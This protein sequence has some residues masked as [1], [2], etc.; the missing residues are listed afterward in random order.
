MKKKMIK[1]LAL[2]LIV[3]LFAVGCQ[4][5]GD[6][7]KESAK[8]TVVIATSSEIISLNKYMTSAAA[9]IMVIANI[10]DS[11]VELDDDGNVIPSLAK[12]WE[13]SDDGISYTFNLEK[14]VKFQNGEELKASDVVFTFNTAKESP[15]SASLGEI[16]DNVKEIDEYTVEVNIIRPYA[17]FVLSLVEVPIFNEKAFDEAGSGEEYGKHPIGTGAYKFV[18]YELGQ[19]IILERFDDY[20]K[21][22]A[23]IKNLVFK[24]ISDMNTQLVALESGDIDFM[25]DVPGIAFDSVSKNEDLKI[26]QQE[27]AHLTF[28]A[29]NVLDET[30]NN[31]LLRQAIN[32]AIDKE[33]LV[34]MSLEGLGEIAKYPLN[35][36]TFG[37]SKEFKGYEYDVEK[38][39][40]LL[41][42][43]GYP[44]G[45]D[46][47]IISIE[48]FKKV[49]EIVQEQLRLIGVNVE[50]KLG[51][52]SAVIEQMQRSDYVVGL[53]G[54]TLPLDAD[55]W[56]WAFQTDGVINLTGYSKPKVDELFI[57]A[58]INTDEDERLKIYNEVFQII[59][60]DALIVPL[61]FK[62]KLQ[63]RNAKLNVPRYD[64]RG[65]PL[66]YL[67]SW[68]Q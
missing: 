65:N 61:F 40:E 4:N 26:R 59:S 38:A 58:Q 24:I 30:M 22:A 2:L 27:T 14:G 21:G 50:I 7:N 68:E 23:S 16:L 44:N 6:S 10:F 17:P 15:F 53:T 35:S 66:I 31:K 48:P 34:E 64:P 63:A 3:C 20:F 67:M 42:V 28:L 19:K 56:S 47:E 51:D 37:Y 62:N 13:V 11:L 36:Q 1:G 54:L 41:A 33:T 29:F 18:K 9:D 46:L 12:Y 25:S 57:E 39:K 8:D 45:L 49:C 55:F 43:A 32:Y 52:A 60:D 5:A